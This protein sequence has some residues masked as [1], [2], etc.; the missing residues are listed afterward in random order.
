MDSSLDFSFF[1]VRIHIMYT[2]TWKHLDID[3]AFSE[4]PDELDFLWPTGPLAGTVGAL[5]APGASGK[6]IYALELAIAVA[7]GGDADLLNLGVSKAGPVMY[8]AMEE[9][10]IIIN[11]RIHYIGRYIDPQTR[12]SI[13]EKLFV[14][15]LYGTSF[16]LISQETIEFL[17]EQANGMRLI[18]LDTLSRLHNL[19]ENNNRDAAIIIATLERL[20]L[21]TGATILYLHHTSKTASREQTG[22]DQHAARGASALID[23]ARWCGYIRR[24]SVERAKELG[25]VD[26]V[27]RKRF[28]EYGVS[29]TNYTMIPD[30][31]LYEFD[32][33]GVLLPAYMEANMEANNEKKQN[34]TRKYSKEDNW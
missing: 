14:R 24:V 11:R 33:F 22:H 6:S 17:A 2:L 10:E 20:S 26:F 34:K 30:P 19:D 29:K 9:P 18:I 32:H 15:V 28:I 5:V 7:S 3:K 4:E 25:F 27:Q 1:F 12:S 23:N 13:T 21:K 16:N 8:L 31:K